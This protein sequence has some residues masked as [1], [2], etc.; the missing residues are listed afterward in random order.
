MKVN[1]HGPNGGRVLETKSKPEP[2]KQDATAVH[3]RSCFS[4]I[5]HIVSDTEHLWECIKRVHGIQSRTE[6]S[7]EQWAKLAA[8]IQASVYSKPVRQDFLQS[9]GYKGDRSTTQA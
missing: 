2:K 7:P 8:R 9:V 3:R 4:N 5:K 1:L 6:L